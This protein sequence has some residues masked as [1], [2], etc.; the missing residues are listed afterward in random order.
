MQFNQIIPKKVP[1]SWYRLPVFLLMMLW[2][3]NSKAQ[4]LVN[5]SVKVTETYNDY[6]CC[7]DAAGICGFTNDFPE[8]R[9]KI[10]VRPYT[11]P[12][13]SPTA[14]IAASTCGT[15]VWDRTI[16]TYNGICEDRVVFEVESWEDD[17]C[18]D[19]M[20]YNEGCV[21]NNDD[22]HSS[23]ESF[24]RTFLGG[25]PGTKTFV[26]GL[27][28]GYSITADVTWS[29]VGLNV[30]TAANR[31]VCRGDKA[32]LTASNTDPDVN[33]IAFRWYSD[34][35]LSTLVF[36][37]NPF[38]TPNIFADRSYWVTGVLEGGCE[39]NPK[40]VDITVIEKPVAP[41]APAVQ[42]CLNGQ[43][44]LTARSPIVGAIFT[45]Y[46]D[47]LGNVP[48]ASGPTFLTPPLSAPRSYWVS[49][50]DPAASCPS[51]LR[52]VPVTVDLVLSAPTAG[53][54]VICAGEEAVLT[55]TATPGAEV[56]WY[57]DEDLTNLLFIGTEFTVSPSGFTTYYLTQAVNG[58]TSGSSSVSVT[59]NPKPVSPVT[60][61]QSVCSSEKYVNVSIPVVSGYSVNIY[62]NGVLKL[63]TPDGRFIYNFATSPATFTT[64]EY[65]YIDN[66]TGCES[67][68][69][70]F[71]IVPYDNVEAPTAPNVALCVNEVGAIVSNSSSQA[72]EIRFYAADATTLLETDLGN[73]GS[74]SV[75]SSSTGTTT[76]YTSA[77]SA[78]GCETKRMRVDVIVGGGAPTT[79]PDAEDATVCSG[80]RAILTAT[81]SV[82]GAM[83]WYSD[84][85]LTNLLFIGNPFETLPLTADATYYVAEGAGECGSSDATEVHVMVNPAASLPFATADYTLCQGQTI[86]GGEGLLATC[87]DASGGGI[88]ST[89][90]EGSGTLPIILGPTG[91]VGGSLSFDGSAIPVGST[92]TSVSLNMNLAH[93]YA[94]DLA[95]D[96]SSP[97][98]LTANV[99]RS[100]ASNDNFGTSGTTPLSYIFNDLA[101]TYV[102][103]TPGDNDIPSGSYLPNEPFS[104][105]TGTNASGI[106]TLDIVDRY[107]D[108]GGLL[109]GASLSI[110]YQLPA[111]AGSLTWWDAP[112]G[113]AQVGSGSPFVPAN[114]ETLPIGQHTYY[115]Q[116][117]DASTCG[118][119]RVAVNL[120]VLPAISSPLVSGDDAVCEGE[121]ANLSVSNPL[122]TVEWYADDNL[123]IFLGTGSSFTTA[124]LTETTTFYVV[125][126]NGNCSSEAS[127]FTVDVNP[128]PSTEIYADP[129][130]SF[131]SGNIEIC[132]GTLVTLEVVLEDPSTQIAL[133]YT[134]EEPGNLLA[135]WLL[136]SEDFFEIN[137]MSD[138]IYY[139]RVYDQS[140]GCFSKPVPIY[141]DVYDRPTD[142]EVRGTT[143]CVD[144]P[145]IVHA[146]VTTIFDNPGDNAQVMVYLITED[147]III[148]AQDVPTG[149]YSF[150]VD[151]DLGTFSDPGT[152]NFMITTSNG[153]CYGTP[154]VVT[155]TV[156][157]APASPRVTDDVVCEGE[158]AMLRAVASEGIVHWYSSMASTDV[159]Q[160]GGVFT[161]PNATASTTYYVS[162]VNETGCESPRVAVGVTVNAKPAA[163]EVEAE[164]IVICLG[165]SATF[166]I[167]NPD[168]DLTYVWSSDPL[169]VD[170]W[171]TGETFETPALSQYTAFYVT[172][173]DEET[174]CTS[175]PSAAWVIVDNTLVI[176]SATATPACEG[177]DVHIQVAAWDVTGAV[178]LYN[179]NLDLV[180]VA[181]IPDDDQGNDDSPW[182]A[183]FY[184]SD[185]PAGDYI[186]YVKEYGDYFFPCGSIPISVVVK[187]FENPQS[188]LV[189]DDTVCAGDA[190]RL[191]ATS[192]EGTIQWYMSSSSDVVLHTGAIFDI[193][194]AYSNSTYWVSVLNENGCESDRVPVS[195]TVNAL[196]ETPLI[197]DVEA[198]YGTPTDLEVLNADPDLAYEWATDPD[199]V[200]S[201]GLGGGIFTTG[202]L[203]QN[204]TYY[205]RAVDLATG[206]VSPAVGVRIFVD[207]TLIV[208]NAISDPVCEGNDA[209]IKVSAWDVDAIVG[210]FDWNLNLVD[211]AVLPDDDQGDDNSP[212]VADFYIPDLAAGEYIY[213]VQEIGFEFYPCGSIPISVLVRV[214]DGP[215]KPEAMNDSPTCE[216]GDV[217]VSALAP[218]ANTYSWSGPNQF[219]SNSQTFTINEVTSAQAGEYIVTVYDLSGCSA[220]DTT[221]V[222]V[223]PVP[224]LGEGQV[225]SYNAPLCERDTLKLFVGTIEGVSYEWKGPNAFTSSDQ[226]PMVPNVTESDNQGFYSVQLTDAV[227][228]CKSAWYTVLVNINKR[229]DNVVAV[230]DGPKCAGETINLS[231]GNVFGASYQWSGPNQYLAD[232]R[233]PS[234]QD[235]Q[236]ENAGTYTVVV[237]VDGC[238]SDP[239]TTEVVVYP[240][241]VAD[242]GADDTTEHGTPIQLNGSGGITYQWTPNM[243][244]T[245][246]NNVPNPYVNPPL[247]ENTYTLT[248]WNEY[249]CSDQ[250]EVVIT[251]IATDKLDIPEVFTPN[252]DG[253]NDTWIIGF[254]SDIGE[255]ELCIYARDGAQLY[256]TKNYANDW[257]GTYKGDPLP[258]GTYWYVIK[259]SEHT[260]KGAVTIRR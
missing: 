88:N 51:N 121:Q 209:V 250:D 135:D 185:L 197:D 92:V 49:V 156:V 140:T 30:I 38:T 14:T 127:S 187:V 257:N 1:K 120:N 93:T 75:S 151:F 108:D 146:D 211:I 17:D 234:I 220:K 152:Y 118:N 31:S 245:P 11:N 256:C 141:I 56:R 183:D 128:L 247:G 5:V 240:N 144:E 36:T 20:E 69:A 218:D 188:P 230:N 99:I 41:I 238:S 142:V 137:T 101:A 119:K 228:G 241:P 64:I 139:V 259:S 48:L 205:V 12:T 224:V 37:G 145:A 175:D 62:E 204:T 254:L 107:D 10:R 221:T 136:I 85:A 46:D 23:T 74:Y 63:I 215:G 143:V 242:A 191:L 50:K 71:Y 182:I 255:Y 166:N 111:D 21:L 100:N 196:P 113:G 106:W 96:L 194:A 15:R 130:P 67:D 8:P 170:V 186:Y 229:P 217:L 216:G 198:C 165:Q 53:N 122:G 239:A 161:I 7:N 52:E 162:A 214:L 173:I 206:C 57:A 124:P 249:G 155:V 66:I 201:F 84:A 94:F 3:A 212:W 226:N 159:L 95:A 207:N 176:S 80:E 33:V 9:W 251:V 153:Y 28:N 252:G 147:G 112:V 158:T 34:A 233:N 219:V 138:M 58:C 98:G 168:P 115:A 109:S 232:V 131:F 193:P 172:A 248:V 54:E 89:V 123:T 223:Y 78:D 125:N 180:D 24:T 203:F 60:S 189:R 134:E 181:F 55:A 79:A 65:S 129:S 246:S 25:G 39:T 163:P 148:D 91:G 179:W 184:I 27:S 169:G 105:F 117:D 160:V 90:L 126:N 6:D 44:L 82:G 190:A 72:V 97:G 13:F 157:D 22:H 76:Y 26:L 213:Y 2:F 68:K 253:K 81:G 73:T 32:T 199:F 43:A 40:K 86:P 18:G 116:C 47:A 4:Q 114:Y 210:L 83:Y 70:N 236:Q 171:G 110:T 178:A 237:T 177:S 104:V 59:V 42:T 103:G 174:G 231:T 102:V 260:Y 154:Q 150:N 45:W 258:D 164:E 132:E 208:S 195:V 202:A 133:L 29:R 244:I 19:P 192:T 149:V 77:V 167:V 16:G 225:P 227:T 235:I 243:Y 61:Q 35:S 222:V 200:Y 87:S